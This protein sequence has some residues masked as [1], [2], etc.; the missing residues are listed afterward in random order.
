MIDTENTLIRMGIDLMNNI[1]DGHY[2]LGIAY[3]NARQYDEAIEQ[4]EKVVSVDTDFIEG[5][6]ALALAYFGQ[7]RLQ[8]AK[9]A[10]LEAL[11]IDATYQPTLVF[12]Q[13][14]DPRVSP[15]PQVSTVPTTQPDSVAT[16]A[17]EKIETPKSV[18]PPTPTTNPVEKENAQHPEDPPTPTTNPV[19]KENVPPETDD[20]NNTDIDKE[21]ERGIVFLANK[22]YPQAEATFKKVI[23]ASPNH[24]IAHYNLAQTYMEIGALTDANIEADE[25]LR[26]N[27]SYEPAM[28]LK[29]G[30]AFLVNKEKQRKLQKKLIRYIMPV[31]IIG[32]IGFI[33]FRYNLFSGMLP[34]KIPPKLL[35]HTTLEDTAN[36]NGYIDAGEKVTLIITISNQ[37]GVGKNLKLHVV[38]KKIVGLQ[39]QAHERTFNIAKNGLETTRIPITANRTVKTKK[40]TLKID[41]EDTYK[42][43]LATTITHLHIKSKFKT[44]IQESED[45]IQVELITEL[46]RQVIKK[47]PTPIPKKEPELTPKSP[48]PEMPKLEEITPQRKEIPLQKD[49]PVVQQK[50]SL[51]IAKL[52][53]SAATVEIEQP[54]SQNIDV[55]T[56]ILETPNLATDARLEL[57]EDSILSPNVSGGAGID[58]AGIT[59]RSDTGVRNPSKGTSKGIAARV[60]KIGAA[61]GT[62]Q[63]GIGKKNGSGTGNSGDR[64]GDGSDTF[65]SIIADLTDDII[66]SSGGRPI[67]VVFVVD[68]SGSMR[69]NINAV[70]K[71]LYQMV[72]AY[73]AS[74]IDYQLGLTHFSVD[75]KGQQNDIQVFQLTR[76]LQTYKRRLYEIQVGGDEN[77]LDA[78]QQTLTQMRFRTNTV[79]HLIVV[80]DEPFT[81]MLGH[82]VRTIIG[83]CKSNE[84]YVNVLGENLPDHKQLAEETGGTWHAVPQDLMQQRIQTAQTPPAT[85]QTIGSFILKDATNMPVDIILFIDGSKSMENKTAYVKE[86]IDLWIRDWDN[87]NINYSLGVVRFR[88]EQSVNMVNVFK[89]PQT[90]KQI[91]SILR[92][93][94][95]GD[96]NLHEVVVKGIR[97]LKLR[98]DVKTH[99]ILITD[100]PGNPKQP[101]AG[102]IALLKDM[103]I[104]V[105]VL[106]ATDTLQ[107]DGVYVKM[108][109]AHK[110]NSPNQ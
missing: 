48:E 70:A 34:E 56:P 43:Q 32:I 66:A 84:A 103:S 37:G 78:I 44:E 39:Y 35:I 65:S 102:T 69:D 36:N 60:S 12:L 101:V 13:A 104:T 109:N 91:H 61:E 71:H 47:N 85:P 40:A 79:K 10:A 89:P 88:A 76:N 97:H 110:Q 62:S 31:V 58:K 27:P 5:Y 8:D 107:L 26:L 20:T 67:D 105:S 87:A 28:Q 83:L 33:V 53:A 80:T 30:L 98:P 73:K 49:V 96:E 18:D 15:T 57:T 74:E 23:K 75:N 86:Q 59:K 1:R 99:F 100:E 24:A 9:D 77:A 29:E 50:S 14:I 81:S 54:V 42:K 19:E 3:L 4:L 22:Q 45:E 11:K 95:Q 55:D 106:G 21:L 51:E 46:P 63:T 38:P 17:V 90:Q 108:P 52:P 68:A 6:H 93:P 72:D 92:L 2:T 94:C 41:V 25:A 82:S 16:P 64:H 7:H